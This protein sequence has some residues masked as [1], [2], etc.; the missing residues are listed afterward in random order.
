LEV[1]EVEGNVDMKRGVES[2]ENLGKQLAR[3]LVKIAQNLLNDLL[4][5]GKYVVDENL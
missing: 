1:S 5:P 4:K 2:F 3:G